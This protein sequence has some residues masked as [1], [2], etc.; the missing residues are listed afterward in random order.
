M[1]DQDDEQ[2]FI[3]TCDGFCMQMERVLCK[4]IKTDA[5]DKKRL[6]QLAREMSDV[7]R[8]FAVYLGNS[9]SFRIF[10]HA[11]PYWRV[12]GVPSK[13]AK[14]QAREWMAA[15]GTEWNGSALSLRGEVT[16][17]LWKNEYIPNGVFGLDVEWTIRDDADSWYVRRDKD[18]VPIFLPNYSSYLY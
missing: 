15:R 11:A 1:L 4:I 16:K 18:G 14:Q 7:R 17:A 8:Q 2:K 6:K 9:S 12:D 13:R 10:N 3:N 5:S